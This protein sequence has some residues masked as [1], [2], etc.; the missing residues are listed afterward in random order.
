MPASDPE[1]PAPTIRRF[2]AA[3][4]SVAG[5]T[6]VRHPRATLERVFSPR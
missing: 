6:G 2:D 5:R 4:A 3:S 1:R